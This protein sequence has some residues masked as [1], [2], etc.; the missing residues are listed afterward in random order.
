MFPVRTDFVAR[1]VLID[2]YSL[3]LLPHSQVLTRVDSPTLL[4]NHN[5]PASVK[6]STALFLQPLWTAPASRLPVFHLS[7]GSSSL[8]FVVDPITSPYLV[9]E[10]IVGDALPFSSLVMVAIGREN[11]PASPSS[12]SPTPTTSSSSSNMTNT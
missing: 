10:L 4:L 9:T 3:S 8:S 2:F 11:P 6:P 12:S 5:S 1:H 7:L